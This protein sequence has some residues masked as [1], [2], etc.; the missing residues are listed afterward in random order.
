MP[1]CPSAEQ[2]AR[3]QRDGCLFPIDCLTP[4]EV[5]HSRGCLEAFEREQGDAF[6][7]DGYGNFDLEPRTTWDF[8][9]ASRA[10]HAA[11]VER[12][13]DSNKLLTVR[14]RSGNVAI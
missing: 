6:G 9:P 7:R 2:I 13:F 10:A 5:R 11:M 4:D 1:A 8:D 12:S 3:C 14:W